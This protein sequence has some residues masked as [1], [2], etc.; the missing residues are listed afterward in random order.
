[1]IIGKIF[2]IN[3]QNSFFNDYLSDIS[4]VN[5]LII[6]VILF[7]LKFIIQLLIYYHYFKYSYSIKNFILKSTIRNIFNSDRLKKK[8]YY[9]NSVRA[10]ESFTSS[11]L[12]S[13]FHIA[14]EIILIITISIYLLLWNFELSIAIF[15]IFSLF[16]Y[17]F[18]K[19]IREKIVFFGKSIINYNKNILNYINYA[20]DGY[21]EILVHGLYKNYFSYFDNILNKLNKNLI[22]F[23]ILKII[24]K[25]FIE[26]IILIFVILIFYYNSNIENFLINSGVFLYAFLR[27]APSIIKIINLTNSINYGKHVMDIIKSDMTDYKPELLSK[28]ENIKKSSNKLSKIFISDLSIKINDKI[29]KFDDLVI[30]KGEKIL[31]SGDSGVGKTT[32]IEL[33]LGLKKPSNG[34]I[35]FVDCNGKKIFPLEISSYCPQ[36]FLLIEGSAFNN[37]ILNFDTRKFPDEP[38][39]YEHYASSLNFSHL[40]DAKEISQLSTG[41]KR[42]VSLLRTLLIN[43]CDLLIFD[44]PTANLDISNANKFYNIIN[45]ELKSKTVI[46]VSHD[47]DSGYIPDKIISL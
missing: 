8:D 35:D 31:I 38:N 16:G 36:D 9:L 25:L 24:P 45:Q 17:L 46:I 15:V 10:I 6:F 4:L 5:I 44:E 47:K 22:L 42:R 30:N 20:T 13:S 27:T 29:L 34:R 26:L 33:I 19:S 32:L 39:F 18:T 7:I 23:D 11:V 21:K 3:S 41:E 28:Y 37:I 1:M 14:F 40:I 2:S 43:D 12:I